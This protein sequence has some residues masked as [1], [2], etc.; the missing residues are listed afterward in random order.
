MS[1]YL[2]FVDETPEGRKTKVIVVRSV[3][4]GDVL[5]LISWFGR[6]RQY[7]LWPA[8]DTIFNVGCMNDISAKIG[9]LMAERR[10]S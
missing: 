3:S 9:E 10:R 4:G 7:C 1:E 6:W 2:D 8:D 5:G